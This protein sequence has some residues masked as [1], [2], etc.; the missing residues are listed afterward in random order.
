MTIDLQR[1]INSS[2]GIRLASAL[3]Q[4][5]PP[6]L[7]H[8]AADLIADL[9]SS[10]RNARVV[11]SIRLNQWMI[12][13]RPSDPHALDAAV[14]ETFRSSARSIFDLHHNIDNP[15]AARKMIVL[16]EGAQELADLP[17]FTDR[18]MVAVGLHMSGFD[19]ILQWLCKQGMKPLVFTIADPQ[20]GRRVEF[21]TRRR[22]GMNLV[23]AS[24]GGLRHA[25]DHLRKGGL[26]VT[27]M[28]RP[29]PDPSTRPSF[30]GHPAALPM[31]HIYMAL[32]ADVPL[33]IFVAHYREDGKYHVLSSPRIEPERHPHRET[34]ALLNA[35]K[36]LL[37]AEDF[38]RRAP[39]QWSVPLAVWPDLMDEVPGP[40]R[41]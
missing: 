26:V 23:P 12:R 28:D 38:I 21:E 8:R 16:D 36:L 9:F 25:A 40:R 14:R 3:A 2:S 11:R 34:E 41:P 39:A 37:M 19:L 31:H 33:R 22:L 20:G 15:N 35:E 6:S 5:A 18:G 24:I 29:V 10:R 27:G 7:G 32:K 17:E 1:I 13:G 4:S 30:F